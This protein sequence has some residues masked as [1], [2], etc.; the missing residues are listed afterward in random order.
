MASARGECPEGCSL[1]LKGQRATRYAPISPPPPILFA[2]LERR[3]T[4]QNAL[5]VG[6][7]MLMALLIV[8][9]MTRFGL[10]Y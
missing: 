10:A 5:T 8:M 6:S 1:R 4:W 9:V 7:L 3:S 2:L